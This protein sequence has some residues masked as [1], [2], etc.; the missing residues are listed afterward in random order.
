MPAAKSENLYAFCTSVYRFSSL[1]QSLKNV[2]SFGFFYI[3]Q[4]HVLLDFRELMSQKVIKAIVA[5]VLV[6]ILMMYA[7][8][9]MTS[10]KSTY[11]LPEANMLEK[12]HM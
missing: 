4:I 6:G 11:L 7:D 3:E 1:I 12:L 10:R 2:R 9:I 5:M 8:H